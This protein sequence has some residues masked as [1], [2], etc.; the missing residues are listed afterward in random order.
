MGLKA[1]L[2]DQLLPGEQVA[3]IV[4]C[5]EHLFSL[6]ALAKQ[7]APT[8]EASSDTNVRRQV[9]KVVHA[10][11]EDFAVCGRALQLDQDELRRF[12]GG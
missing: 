3:T 10:V 4:A 9:D 12:N 7:E 5:E 8:L 2:E 1:Q 11:E 6:R